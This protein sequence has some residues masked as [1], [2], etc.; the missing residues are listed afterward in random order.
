MIELNETET[1][2]FRFGRRLSFFSCLAVLI[3]GNLLSAAAPNF[4]SWA[5]FRFIVGL[6]VPAIYQIPFIIC[7]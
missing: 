4:W 1:H 7:K 6:T 2:V 3:I 5:V